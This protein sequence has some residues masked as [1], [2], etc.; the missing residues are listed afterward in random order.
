[1]PKAEELITTLDVIYMLGFSIGMSESEIEEMLLEDE[2]IE[3]RPDDC[4]CSDQ[5]FQVYGCM[6]RVRRMPG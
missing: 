5:A 2:I 6:C 3:S 1:M 4:V